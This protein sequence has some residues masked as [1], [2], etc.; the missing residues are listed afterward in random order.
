MLPRPAGRPRL[1]VPPDHP[2]PE[3]F[4]GAL[5]AILRDSPHLDLVRYVAMAVVSRR[6]DAL[7]DAMREGPWPAPARRRIVEEALAL[8]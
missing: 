8:L 7:I 2:V 5:L 3:R 1:E 4:D 6:R